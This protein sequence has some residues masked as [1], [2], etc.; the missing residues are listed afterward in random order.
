[1]WKRFDLHKSRVHLRKGLSLPLKEEPRRWRGWGQKNPG[2]LAGLHGDA[3]SPRLFF[4]LSFL[5]GHG[6]IYP[7]VCSLKIGSSCSRIVAFQVSFLTIE[8]IHV[9]H[10]VV[11]LGAELQSPV[12]IIDPVL[13]L[14]Y[15][16]KAD[17]ECNSAPSTT[18]QW[19]T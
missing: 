14:L 19:R 13:N 1:M 11:V 12:Q 10:C 5:R 16:E 17:L 2:L 8:Q 4:R 15:R 9:R 3:L 18:T 7:F 6:L